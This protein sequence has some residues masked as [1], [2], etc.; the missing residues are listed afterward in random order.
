MMASLGPA[1]LFARRAVFS[2]VLVL[3]GGWIAYKGVELVR[4]DQL[5]RAVK[6]ALADGLSK[7]PQA[8]FKALREQVAGWRDT[9]GLRSLART[10]YQLTGQAMM[11]P[12]SITMLDAAEVLK[13]DPANGRAWMDVAQAAWA[14]PGMQTISLA[15]WEM[16]SIAA[17]R[18]YPELRSRMAFL[19]AIW[20]SATQEQKQRFF[21]EASFMMR[22]RRAYFR[23]DWGQML[24]GIPQSDRDAI[25]TEFRAY[26]PLYRR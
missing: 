13:V 7:T 6:Q 17:P 5:D 12:A 10:D 23:A 11:L 22:L 18:E 3:G 16:S 2:L 9:P 8:E 25:E 4:F 15:A 1:G 20:P 14:S 26:Y 19:M 24:A 21:F